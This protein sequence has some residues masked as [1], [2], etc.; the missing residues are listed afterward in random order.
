MDRLEFYKE[1]YY[2]ELESKEILATRFTTN[3]TLV[4]FLFGGL[5]FCIKNL[6]D[7][8][9]GWFFYL[10]LVFGT[11][12]IIANIRI[13]I[14]LC[15]YLAGREYEF[16]HSAKTLDD[17]HTLLKNHYGQY[18]NSPDQADIQFEQ[19]IINY[20]ISA[21]N[22]NFHVND[23]RIKKMGR[24]QEC[25]IASVIATLLA[26]SCYIPTFLKEDANVQKVEIYKP[27]K[28]KDEQVKEKAKGEPRDSHK[29]VDN[30][31]ETNQLSGDDENVK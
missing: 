22:H 15:E 3:V 25:I 18:P 7:I 23:S 2:K 16:I 26:I 28:E 21:A 5:F 4:T 8:K 24:A 19:E 6:N 29:K 20:Y 9:G 13:L 27:S 17:R 10:F 1:L 12:A 30:D 14:L 31:K 11:I